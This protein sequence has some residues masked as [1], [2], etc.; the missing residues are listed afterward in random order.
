MKRRVKLRHSDRD[1]MLS[2]VLWPKL[3]DHLRDLAADSVGRSADSE[4]MKR[5][6]FRMTEVE[7][8]EW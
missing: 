8:G 5:C 7:A 1:T 3:L 2:L 4:A 6:V